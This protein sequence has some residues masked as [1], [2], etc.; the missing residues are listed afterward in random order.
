MLYANP[1]PSSIPALGFFIQSP[2]IT[3]NLNMEK[4][5]RN[6]KIEAGT[7]TFTFDKKVTD[8]ILDLSGIG[9]NFLA[10]N[11][12]GYGNNYSRGSFNATDF[13]LLTEG[14][15]FEKVSNAANLTI[16]PNYIEVT[17]KNTNTQSVVVDEYMKPGTPYQSP[18]TVAAG[19]GS[20][21]LK[22]T[23]DKV[24]IKLYHRTT[25][26]SAFEDATDPYKAAY[27]DKNYG[28][29]ING[30]NVNNVESIN[31]GGKIFTGNENGDFFRLSFRLPKPSSIG[32]TIW[33]DT[34]ENGI[35]DED[36]SGIDGV[37]VKLLDKDGNQAKD[38]YGNPIADQVT[39]DGGKY[40]FDNLAE[41][42]Y[43]IKVVTK[44]DQEITKKSQGE[45]PT[46]DSDVNEEGMTDLINLGANTNLTDIDAGVVVKYKV[47]HEFKSGTEGKELP[48]EV[49]NLTPEDQTGKKDGEEV[50][51]TVPEKTTVETEEG[52]WTF[53]GYDKDKDTIDKK[54]S[55]FVGT[56]VFEEKKPSTGNVYVKYITEDGE[57]LEAE[58]AVK[59]NAPVGEEYTT[60]QKKFEGYEFVRM[61]ED[62]ASANGEVAEEDQHVIYV[63]KKVEEYKVTH[64]FKSGTE[65]K[66][67]PEEVKNLTPEDQTGKKDGEEVTPTAPEKTTVETE[68]GTWTFKGYDKDKDT[69]DKKD[70]H[71]VGTWVFEEKKPST[72]NVYVK[73]ITEDGEV[74]EAESVVKENAPVGEEYT[75]EQKKFEGYEFVRMSE[76]S[77]DANGNVVEGDQYVTYVYKAKETPKPSTGNVYVKYITEDGEVLEAESVVKENTPVGE[78]YTTEQKQF[79][80]YEFVRMSEDSADANGN[81]VEGDQYVVYVYKAKETPG[82]D[83]EEKTGNVYV[84][85]ITEDGE[86]LEAES[87]VKENAPVG[88]EYTTEQK[89]FEGYEFV[90]MSE[91]SA[92]ANGNVVEGDQYVTYVYKAKETPKPS[93]GNVYVK[94]I[95]EDGEVLEA[96]SVVKE[97]APVGEEYTTEQKAFEGYEFVRMDKGSA[98]STGKVSK[99]DQ[100][101]VYV[102]KKEK[103]NNDVVTNYVDED[104]N[105]ISDQEKGKKDKKDIKGYEYVKTTEDENGNTTHIYKKIKTVE[106]KKLDNNKDNTKKNSS[107]KAPKTGVKSYIAIV[108]GILTAAI[109]GFVFL[110]KKK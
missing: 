17:N 46:I 109:G 71:F 95:T 40:K 30:Y 58:S 101:I 5:N 73:Y 77:A 96:E 59:E 91:D 92:D 47:T 105:V 97:N 62:S 90:R 36:E 79:E 35:Q 98:P 21:K 34:N 81:V 108:G 99:E 23:F 75:T 102:Y 66:E 76:D 37:I 51:P 8:P 80:G 4:I 50:T 15:E 13:E 83:P 33:Q 65:G 7:V 70:S 100:L 53:K 43:Y 72:G 88:E 69:I 2:D 52:T 11:F 29:G 84:K 31:I 110:S 1:N 78:E 41:G 25:P 67:L 106:P 103:T 22:G 14:V 18:K 20:V 12:D 27:K 60:E 44:D 61:S 104:G 74:L 32:D 63:Y 19:T 89:K 42:E 28:D 56:W 86:V 55:H 49:K 82:T 39:K 38:Y 87:V 16:T 68:E 64:E 93:T 57:V 26:F 24:S 107:K 10:N 85:Y 45:D 54:D 9:G 94:Y 6:G 48:E 3:E